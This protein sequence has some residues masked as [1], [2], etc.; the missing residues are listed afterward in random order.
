[1]MNEYITGTSVRIKS[2][3]TDPIAGGL[4]DPSALILSVMTPDGIVA[5]VSTLIVKDEVG[6]YHADY[7]T[8]QVGVHRYSWAGSGTVAAVGKGSFKTTS[9][10]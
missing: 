7:I 5:D 6:I 4:V 9:R 2:Q 10:I 1:M 8:S 3:V